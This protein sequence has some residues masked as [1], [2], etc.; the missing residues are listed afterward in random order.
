[1][2]V[3]S[4]ELLALEAGVE[5]FLDGGRRDGPG[6]GFVVWVALGRVVAELNFGKGAS[7]STSTSEDESSVKQ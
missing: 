1:M 6:S 7:T 3:V 4:S 5:C 2:P